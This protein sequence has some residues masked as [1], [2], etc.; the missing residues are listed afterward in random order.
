MACI[1]API[2][3]HN[4]RITASLNVGGPIHRFNP[5]ESARI[6]TREV[7]KAAHLICEKMGCPMIPGTEQNDL[8]IG[9][10]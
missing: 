8:D 9:R 6:I 7:L 5:P 4:S 3:D 2:F 1:A 10:E